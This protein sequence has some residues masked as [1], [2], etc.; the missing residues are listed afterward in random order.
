MRKIIGV[1]G[2]LLVRRKRDF[3]LNVFKSFQMYIWWTQLNLNY[4][5][6]RV[7]L[8]YVIVLSKSESFQRYHFKLRG[9]MMTHL[10]R[11]I[12]VLH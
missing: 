12:S 5:L 8:S 7:T 9:C 10:R 2:T 6:A 11:L 4:L 1:I 3:F